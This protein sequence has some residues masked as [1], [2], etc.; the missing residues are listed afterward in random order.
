MRDSQL[1]TNGT[2]CNKSIQIFAYADDIDKW[3]G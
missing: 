2:I 3:A 1:E